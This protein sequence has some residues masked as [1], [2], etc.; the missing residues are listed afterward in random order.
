VLVRVLASLVPS[1]LAW[2]ASQALIGWL[3]FSSTR[4]PAVVGLALV[5]RITP[6][7]LT[8]V[9]AGALS[10]RVGPLRLLAAGNAIG[11]VVS[12]VLASAA[13]ATTPPLAALLLLSAGYG[14]GDA[15]RMV[16]GQNLAY[17]LSGRFGATR[18]IAMANL[19][20]GVG[21]LLGG[22][23]AG[24]TLD[25]VGAAATAAAV[26][27]AYAA[28]GLSL[29]R[30]SHLPRERSSP[31]PS[32][33]SG[34]RDGLRLLRQLPAIRLLIT[35]ALV[36]ELFG[37][38]GMALDSIFAGAVFVAGPGGLGAILA[39]RAAGRIT[40]AGVLALFRPRAEIGRWL[41]VAAALFG[42][43]LVGYAFAP[44]LPSALVLMWVTGVAAVLVDALA[45]TAIQ[46]GVKPALR[47][48]ASGLWVVT[49]GLGP[50]GVLEVGVVAQL[51]G[52]RLAQAAN[53]VVVLVFGLL[54][55]GALGR[56]LRPGGYPR[57]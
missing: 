3:V 6:L 17:D 12:L 43:G 49:V 51:I 48:A 39:A 9:P 45:Q 50:I 41:A 33:L 31:V 14:V 38:S 19:V 28:G 30:L 24:V 34:V 36:V 18:A 52:A 21:Q 29:V 37:F 8:G 57:G 32:L 56:R 44:A 55:L 35:V 4:S 1:W 22:T 42:A 40:G 16:G 15:A 27:A 47:G 53:G 46:D 5:V 7:A 23:L 11:A 10:D 26:G 20:S 25:T 2:A 13:L 54:L